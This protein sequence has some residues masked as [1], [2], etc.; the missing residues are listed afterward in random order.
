LE[1]TT[2]NYVNTT[3]KKDTGDMFALFIALVGGY[4][5]V[6]I[7]GYVVHWA[8][9]RPELGKA[10]E[11]HKE[12]HQVKY[13]PEN[14]LS[15]KYR[16]ISIISQPFW[17]YLPAAIGLI[18]LAFTT[19]PLYIAGAL[20]AELAFVAWSNDWV[21]Q[22]LHIEGHWLERYTWFHR[23]RE[24]H[25]QHHLDEGTNLGIFSW[26]G[27]RIFGTFSEAQ[28]LAPYL[29]K[30]E[31]G[32]AIWQVNAPPKLMLVVDTEIETEVETEVEVLHQS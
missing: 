8:L 11:A 13:P 25:W 5:T 9:H 30:P 4:F 29:I 22:K 10:F 28:E 12:H 16:E 26:T 18:A 27:D 17:Y 2:V 31:P 23:L 19:L 7:S 14:Y 3:F 24:L 20:T 32:P 15:K 6:Q 21:H 1:G